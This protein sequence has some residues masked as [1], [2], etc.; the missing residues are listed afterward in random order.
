LEHEIVTH[1]A[2]INWITKP[3]TTSMTQQDIDPL[4]FP[5]TDE[6]FGITC[7][8]GTDRLN[9]DFGGP[10]VML[11]ESSVNMAQIYPTQLH[12][13]K[14][15]GK[16]ND[17]YSY[18]ATAQHTKFAVTPIHTKEEFALYNNTVS[19]GGEEWCPQAGKPIFHKM[20]TW[21][22]SKADGKTIFYKLPEHLTV[23]HKKWV[24]R[25]NRSQSMVASEQQRQAHTN[26][27]RSEHH[28]AWA[29]DPSPRDQPGVAS[30]SQNA[31]PTVTVTLESAQN[32]SGPSM[33]A[34]VASHQGSV[35]EDGEVDMTLMTEEMSAQLAQNLL[36]IVPNVI[37]RPPT[38][39]MA[40]S[41]T[42][43]HYTVTQQQVWSA[44]D[45]N[46]APWKR[47]CAVCREAGRDGSDCPGKSN[48]T[49]CKYNCKF[50]ILLL[51]C[52]T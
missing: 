18:L 38:M 20:A 51:L 13:S 23:Y 45:P 29:L 15:K 35:V 49:L 48:R 12:L 4:A 3:T 46:S 8:P 2:D 28:R 16:R 22:S 30:T 6:Q 9:C 50:H 33:F 10:L 37:F 14:L 41:Q 40:Q 43:G 25:R 7:I 47:R 5:P 26:R 32:N 36:P 17:V 27:V 34:S 42:S 19:C 24:E 21:W 1:R 11:S 44:Y 31:S 39:S 52:F